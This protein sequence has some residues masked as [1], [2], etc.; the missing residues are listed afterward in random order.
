[1]MRFNH[2]KIVFLHEEFIYLSFNFSTVACKMEVEGLQESVSS[3]G[4]VVN[5]EVEQ[6]TEIEVEVFVEEFNKELIC[7]KDIE[8]EYIVAHEIDLYGNI[9]RE[10]GVFQVVEGEVYVPMD[11]S[12]K[13]LH[14]FEIINGN[15]SFYISSRESLDSI[16]DENSHSIDIGYMKN[17]E[18]P[19]KDYITYKGEEIEYKDKKI[20]ESLRPYY[21]I[22]TRQ[23]E[24]S[25]A[26]DDFL[27]TNDLHYE[28]AYDIIY[29]QFL[30]EDIFEKRHFPKK[31]D[32]E[33]SI[34]RKPRT[35]YPEY[36]YYHY[37]VPNDIPKFID[38]DLEGG[39]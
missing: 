26:V 32:L 17:I 22:D 34:K 38:V 4:L 35:K 36:D 6:E 2:R 25:E 33:K 1:M 27:Y 20:N 18:D 5:N 39:T 9:T 30:T 14:K 29:N 3:E 13:G 7:L 23:K 11:V 24:I 16:G 28:V 31:F 10:V 8:A 15:Q 19:N 21:T 37:E 12:L